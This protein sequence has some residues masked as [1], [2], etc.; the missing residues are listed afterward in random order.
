MTWPAQ[1]AATAKVLRLL[2]PVLRANDAHLNL[3]T[4]EEITSREVVRLVEEA[5]PDAFG[6]TFD[7][8]N[9]VV[10]GED[11]VAAARRV[12]PYV[13][14]THLRDVGLWRT[15]DGIGRFLLPVGE[16]VLDWD[17]IL[18]V[19]L[20]ANPSVPLSVE[21]V[22][23]TRAEMPLWVD[24]PRWYAADPDLD[25]HELATLRSMT[26]AYEE[27]AEAGGALALDEL[28]GPV[29][30]DGALSFVVSSVEELRRVGARVAP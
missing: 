20:V 30:D 13:R 11:P 22:I 9:V 19:L 8:A 18:A 16:G 14:A 23:G 26:T 15:A 2:A 25:A 27:R 17:A 28:R 7:S 24:D 5:G 3:E 1:L 6:V 12:A 29:D 4:H 21:G 10:R